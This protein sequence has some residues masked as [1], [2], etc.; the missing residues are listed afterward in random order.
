[1]AIEATRPEYQAL[2]Q[3]IRTSRGM[4]TALPEIENGSEMRRA[5]AEQFRLSPKMI[6]ILDNSR[7]V[8]VPEAF[9]S[10]YQAILDESKYRDAALGVRYS[11]GKFG[12][13]QPID[14]LIIT[15]PWMGTDLRPRIV[16]GLVSLALQDARE[17]RFAPN[18]IKRVWVDDLLSVSTEVMRSS[19]SVLHPDDMSVKPRYLGESGFAAL[20]RN[21]LSWAAKNDHNIFQALAKKYYEYICVMKGVLP[22]L[23]FVLDADV[24]DQT[25]GLLGAYI[26]DVR[27]KRGFAFDNIEIPPSVGFDE[28]I[29]DARRGNV[30]GI[31]QFEDWHLD[32]LD[33]Y[34]HSKFM[35]GHANYAQ[36]PVDRKRMWLEGAMF[37]DDFPWYLYENRGGVFFRIGQAPPV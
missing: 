37:Q 30:T 1:M 2:R 3:L 29:E 24:A 23:G 9:S 27:S 26:G 36:R 7:V 22:E 35:S 10:A 6:K 20:K 34:G 21:G 16:E 12:K 31:G 32:D 18:L 15:E 4:L 5:V 28:V 11:S 14:S 25:L 33:G 19:R 17:I 13:E 8:E